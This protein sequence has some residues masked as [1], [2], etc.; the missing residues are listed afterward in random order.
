MSVLRC[1]SCHGELYAS[2]SKLT[3]IACR[4]AYPV[5]DEI[6]D[7]SGGQYYDTYDP[8]TRLSAE[9]EQGLAFEVEGTRRR[10]TDFYEPHL[11]E[12]HAVRVLD[13]GTGNGIAV[14]LLNNHGFDAWGVD[15]SA[16]RKHQWRQRTRRDRLVV[17][18]VA[19]LPFTD[20]YFDAVIA[21]GVIEHIGVLEARSPHYAVTPLP[22]RDV[23]RRHVL[24]ELLRVTTQTGTVFLDFPNGTFPIDFWHGDAPGQARWHGRN[25]GFLPRFEE[26]QQLSLGIDSALHIKALSPYRRLQFV[27]SAAQWYGRLLA[28]PGDLYFRAMRWRTMNWLARTALNPFLVLEISKSLP[29]ERGETLTSLTP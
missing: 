18:D 7:F 3:C 28:V 25:E 6:V 8:S 15:L 16:L 12:R 13:C 20:G 9:A 23:K 17:G 10:I 1:P 22:D 14:D 27:Q 2:V 26:I 21:S 4:R 5:E 24:Q 11:R 29:K 19:A